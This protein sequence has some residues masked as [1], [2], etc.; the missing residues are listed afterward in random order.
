[1]SGTIGAEGQYIV[2]ALCAAGVGIAGRRWPGG[3]IVIPP[4]GPLWAL[5]AVQHGH[6]S[7]HFFNTRF[8][9][10]RNPRRA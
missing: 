4:D 2:G 5:P 7:R 10:Q 6:Q 9:G 1:M 3:G 8:S